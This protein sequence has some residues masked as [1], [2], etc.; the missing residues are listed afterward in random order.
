MTC[1]IAPFRVVQ[2][3]RV[4]ITLMRPAAERAS[5]LPRRPLRLPSYP[6]ERK[7]SFAETPLTSLARTC[8]FIVDTGG[9]DEDSCSE[10]GQ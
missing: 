1:G 3:F 10:M 8:I 4:E 5:R 7:K 2:E 6:P 9:H